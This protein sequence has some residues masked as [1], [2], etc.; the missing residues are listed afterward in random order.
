MTQKIDQDHSRFRKIV[1]G[2]IKQN[3]RKYIS[4]GELIGR[5]GQQS[6]TIPLPQINTPRFR[7]GAKQQ[8]GVGQGQGNVGDGLA[9]GEGEG[10]AG[11]AGGQPGEHLIEVEV[12]LEELASI[13]GE[14]LELPRIEPRGREHIVAERYR[15][16]SVRR[17]GPNSLR[18][19]KRTFK[20]ALRRQLAMGTY[21]LERPLI[22]PVR[23]DVRYR[24]WRRDPLPETNAVI[25]YMMDVSGSMGD[26]QKEIVRIESFW[27]DTWLRAQYRGLESRYLIH[28]A[29]AKEVDRDTFFRTRESGGTMISSAYKLCAQIIG[30]DYSPSEWNIYPFHF[31]DGDNWSVDD[32]ALCMRLLSEQI[33][34]AVNVFCYGQVESPYGSGQFLKDLRQRFDFER[35]GVIASEI[36]N[37]EAI[38]DSIRTFL[39][40]GH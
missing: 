23:D 37:R 1:R 24:S 18:H 7:L 30:E 39:G 28:D 4:Q 6:V 12:S 11:A 33:V 35:D 34:P 26:E 25:I 20:Q 3:L 9:P 38:V 36:A 17:T 16:T 29:T 31:S 8:G 19:F 5:Q 40:K 2:R 21:D 27:I 32:T 15:Y 22:V 13:L 10:G 14:E